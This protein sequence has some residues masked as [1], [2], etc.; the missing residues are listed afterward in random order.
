L[1]KI[2]SDNKDKNTMQYIAGL[3][4][5]SDNMDD[6]TYDTMYGNAMSK[7]KIEDPNAMAYTGTYS[8]LVNL[9]GMTADSEKSRTFLQNSLASFIKNND[10]DSVYTTITQK[11]GESLKGAAGT[12]FQQQVVSYDVLKDLEK[13]VSD[14]ENAGGN[15]NLLKGT[16]DKIQSNIGVLMTDP[17]YAELAVR[18]DSAFYQYR[19]NMTGAAFGAQESRQ[20]ASVIPSKNNTMELNKAKFKGAGDYL[21]SNIKSSIRG[22]FGSQAVDIMGKAMGSRSSG[23]DNSGWSQGVTDVANKYGITLP[24]FK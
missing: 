22:Q 11:T 20:Y 13:A 9:L 2:A 18:L 10:W 15:M 3:I 7:L 16:E 4:T 24:S 19:Q 8:P 5:Q 14:Y 17:R 23:G 21:Y 1:Y 6:K 12:T